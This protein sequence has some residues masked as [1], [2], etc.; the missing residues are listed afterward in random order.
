MKNLKAIETEYRGY[1]FRSRLEARWAVFFDACRVQWEYE[2]EGY[3]LENGIYYLP[4][5]LLHGVVGKAAGDLFVEVKGVMTA[6]DADKINAF[7]HADRDD[8]LTIAKSRY[9][10]LV[11]GQI[12][13]GASLNELI[14]FM[15]WNAY[16]AYGDD[17]DTVL[18]PLPFN[19]D[20]IDGDYRVA[21]PGINRRGQF[22]LFTDAPE[23]L[24]NM[25]RYAT[26]YAFRRARQA[27]FE[28]GE[29][30]NPRR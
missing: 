1:R 21:I 24:H 15:G 23:S 9:A 26:Q 25:N 12:P 29:T 20:S 13:A 8:P 7:V 6:P 30:P 19:F 17:V 22:E 4:D 18:W 16:H 3:D 2:P 5:F 14:N 28:H 11:V 10:T 27:R